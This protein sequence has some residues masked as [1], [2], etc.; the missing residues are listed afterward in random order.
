MAHTNCKQCRT[1]ILVRTA[2]HYGGKCV[3]CS[4]RK[5][6]LIA[7]AVL[8]L[9]LVLGIVCIPCCVAHELVLSIWQRIHFP[10]DFSAIKSRL[11]EIYPNSRDAR[12][13]KRNVIRGFFAPMLGVTT[14]N[15]WNLPA[16]EGEMDGSRLAR[17]ELGFE[18]LPTRQFPFEPK[19]WAN[20]IR[21][22]SIGMGD[23]DVS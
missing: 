8:L 2:N 11:Q 10:Y 19:R 18:S 13:Y 7:G 3:P 16:I 9:H 22:D 21:T 4:R 15:P 20:I 1:Q 5:S 17:N 23:R 12:K 6:G 14:S